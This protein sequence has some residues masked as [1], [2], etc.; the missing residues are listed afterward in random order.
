MPRWGAR[1]RNLCLLVACAASTSCI[2][3]AASTDTAGEQGDDAHTRR[4][5]FP[6]L[7]GK[8]SA[9]TDEA[10]PSSFVFFGIADWGGQENAPYTTPGQLEVA[11]V[12]GVVAEEGGNHPAFVIAA[13]DNFYM[14][15]LPGAP[16]HP[17][18]RP[19]PNPQRS[20][21]TAC[22]T[23]CD[24]RPPLWVS[25]SS[26]SQ[27]LRAGLLP[28]VAARPVWGLGPREPSPPADSSPF[29]TLPRPGG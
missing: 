2:A 28:A 18:C 9:A 5:L 10:F 24:L 20:R 14:D 17:R 1:S 16:S 4:S 27:P 21:A 15:G 29:P 19:G 3:S 7:F 26:Q 13:G 8:G 11:E 12:M 6:S 25:S 22:C 23:Q